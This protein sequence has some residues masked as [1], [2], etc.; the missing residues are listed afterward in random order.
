M[1]CPEC[2]G[3]EYIRQGP[4]IQ[5]VEDA[6]R[7]LLPKTRVI[8]MDADTTRGK[9]AHWKIVEQFSRGEGD[10]L[11]G[12]QMVAKGHDFPGVT[13]AAV[14]GAEMGLYLPDFRA[15]ETTFDLLLQVAGRSGRSSKPGEVIIQTLDPDNPVIRMACSH[16]YETFM[17]TELNQ[18]KAMGFPP[19]RRMARLLC[20][21]RIPP[22]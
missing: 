10:V 20:P 16:D 6:L 9:S 18:R 11:L 17:E 13:L 14:I 19:F 1:R 8:R 2:S 5:K 4:G 3:E 21:G 22:G 7:E 12:T 15:Q